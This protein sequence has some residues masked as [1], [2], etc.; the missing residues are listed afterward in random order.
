MRRGNESHTWAFGLRSCTKISQ[1]S[2]FCLVHSPVSRLSVP[3]SLC[4]H[5]LVPCWGRWAS[6]TKSLIQA[7]NTGPLAPE[8]QL[9]TGKN[10]IAPSLM[11]K[12]DYW[13]SLTASSVGRAG[14]EHPWVS[15]VKCRGWKQT[16]PAVSWAVRL[17]YQ[18]HGEEKGLWFLSTIN[19][20]LLMSTVGWK[21]NLRPKKSL[22][23]QGI[24]TLFC[25]SLPV[26]WQ[27]KN[28][29]SESRN[30]CV[31]QQGLL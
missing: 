25:G 1:C 10:V 21:T 26:S 18:V 16:V 24:K 17:P 27:S 8:K 4:W 28:L 29:I 31:V 11:Q 20:C 23:K 30:S 6:L 3:L 12:R 2:S 9:K 7:R 22:L 14:T 13:L 15:H 19:F 5:C